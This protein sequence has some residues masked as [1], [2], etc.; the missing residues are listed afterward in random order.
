MRRLYRRLHNSIDGF[1]ELYN[2]TV[3]AT[4]N[5]LSS[6]N[7]QYVKL[8]EKIITDKFKELFKTGISG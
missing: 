1:N 2:N 7:S 8:S 3:N 5:S 6:A 4:I